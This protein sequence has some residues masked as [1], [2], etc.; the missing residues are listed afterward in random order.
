MLIARHRRVTDP[1]MPFLKYARQTGFYMH[2]PKFTSCYGE[3]HDAYWKRETSEHRLTIPERDEELG[4]REVV[5]PAQYAEDDDWIVSL[6]EIAEGQKLAHSHCHFPFLHQSYSGY[7]RWLG[8][9]HSW[10]WF[11]QGNPYRPGSNFEYSRHEPSRSNRVYHRWD[12]FDWPM[13]MLQES[14]RRWQWR[15]KKFKRGWAERHPQTTT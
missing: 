7:M 12:T 4:G 10:T 14:K 3:N 6:K 8:K 13:K 1:D 2:L 15:L 9:R 11:Y 5:I